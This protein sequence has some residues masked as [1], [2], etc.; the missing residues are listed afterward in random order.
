MRIVVVGAG[1]VGLVTGA[2][3]SEFGHQVVC[4]D[5]DKH[6]ISQLRSGLVPIFEPGLADII[7]ENARSG[8]LSFSTDLA[9]GIVEAEA[10]F[11]AVGTPSR[12]EDGSADTAGVKAVARFI[13]DHAKNNLVVVVKSTVPVG[14]TDEVENILAQRRGGVRLSVAFNPEF[15]REGTALKDFFHPDRIV[16]GTE[17]SHARSVLERIYDTPILVGVPRIHTSARTA[18]LV[19]YASNVFL[20]MKVAFVNEMADL[21]EKAG[22]D[23]L[24]LARGVGADK[25]IGADFLKPGPGYGGSCFPKD[26]RALVHKARELGASARIIDAVVKSNDERK[27]A[28]AQ[29]A[30]AACGGSVE[31]KTIAVFGLTFK[32]G[33]DDMRDAPSITVIEALT[34]WGARIRAFDPAGMMNAQKLMPGPTYCRDVYEAAAGAH[35]IIVL[36]DWEEFQSVD[37]NKLRSLMAR[38]SILDLRNMFSGPDVRRAGFDYQGVGRG[39]EQTAEYARMGSF[40]FGPMSAA[41]MVHYPIVSG[42]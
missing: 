1:Y 38:P 27:L 3:L 39:S 22:A 7:A 34:Q 42:E 4:V 36:T 16:I 5:R 40:E 6:R 17:D 9:D 35:L 29:K 24:D 21:C 15:L 13:A 31:G 8:R 26:T 41:G 30:A 33:T 2:C 20:A 25:R 23:V 28:M 12:P 32:P 10:V 14:T 37:L 11:I 19:K 18:E